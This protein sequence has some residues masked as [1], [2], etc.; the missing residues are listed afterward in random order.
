MGVE[1]SHP[2]TLWVFWVK[3][4]DPGNLAYVLLIPWDFRTRSTW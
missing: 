2:D 4:K 3:V 1:E